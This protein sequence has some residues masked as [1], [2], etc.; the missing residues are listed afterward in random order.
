M[1]LISFGYSLASFLSLPWQQIL[2]YNVYLYVVSHGNTWCNQ[3]VLGVLKITV[4]LFKGSPYRTDANWILVSLHL[5]N[6]TPMKIHPP[7]KVCHI[8]FPI[9]QFLFN[10]C[11]VTWILLSTLCFGR[12]PESQN[13]LTWNLTCH[14]SYFYLFI[15]S[16]PAAVMQYLGIQKSS[17]LGSQL[18]L[19]RL[20]WIFFTFWLILK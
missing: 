13:L 2:P 4:S 11:L 17:M 7:S 10:K 18:F 8:S 16:L 15:I 1:H 9:S 20:P 14:I 19:L 12:Y 5:R 3:N 6:M